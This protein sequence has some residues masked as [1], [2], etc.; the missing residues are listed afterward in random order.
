MSQQQLSPE[1][2]IA[3]QIAHTYFVIPQ[4]VKLDKRKFEKA[5]MAKRETYPIHTIC[6]LCELP[7]GFHFGEVCPKVLRRV[8]T[9]PFVIRGTYFLPLLEVENIPMEFEPV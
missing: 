6:A 8:H 5:L 2:R 4:D 7:W 9:D 3:Y 1:Q